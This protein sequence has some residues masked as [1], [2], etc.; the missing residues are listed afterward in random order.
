MIKRIVIGFSMVAVLG[1]AMNATGSPRLTLKERVVKASQKGSG[2][3]LS[4]EDFDAFMAHVS[5]GQAEWIAMLPA[6]SQ[7]VDGY[8]AESLGISLAEALLHSPAEVLKV[9]DDTG[10]N[11][12]L[13]LKHICSVPFIEISWKEVRD[14]QRKANASV[15]RLNVPALNAKKKACLEELNRPAGS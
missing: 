14:Y 8:Y 15:K 13:E 7:Q 3:A 1:G 9:A 11:V 4:E 6:L 12:P 10:N 5:K 2:Y